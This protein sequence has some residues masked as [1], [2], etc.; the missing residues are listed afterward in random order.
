[1]KASRQVITK[2][3]VAVLV[4]LYKHR[5]LSVSQIQRLHFPSL[6]TAYRRL[7]AL[8]EQGMVEGFVVP[9]IPEHVYYLSE[10]GAAEVAGELG[11]ELAALKWSKHS[12]SPKDYYFLRHFLKIND[13]RIDLAQGCQDAGMNLLG[14]IPEYVGSR[15]AGGGLARYI[16]DVVCDARD[17][18]QQLSHTPDAVFGLEKNGMPALFFLEIDRGTEV[19]SDPE[20]GVLKACRFY[21]NLLVDGGFQRYS[22]DF[23]CQGAFRG[24]RALFVTSSTQRLFNMRQAVSGFDFGEKAKKFIWFAVDTAVFGSTIFRVAW[25]SGDAQDSAVYRIG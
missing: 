16:R 2:R 21:L 15:T 1:M 6:Q 17:G 7:R 8:R 24:F 22:Q 11:V 23:G 3:D 13:F 25:V 12:R 4:D 18:G 5:Y 14:F 9:N 20:K 19:V 10:L